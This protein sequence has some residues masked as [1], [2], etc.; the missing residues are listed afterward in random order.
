MAFAVGVTVVSLAFLALANL[1][2]LKA[3]WSPNKQG[4]FYTFFCL[5]RALLAK[6]CNGSLGNFFV[7][8]TSA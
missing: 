7:L 3:D 6:K 2:V 5:S 8:R 4:E 1:S